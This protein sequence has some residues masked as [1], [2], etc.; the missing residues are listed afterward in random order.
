VAQ[1]RRGYLRPY[2]RAHDRRENPDA[3]DRGEAQNWAWPVHA[4]VAWLAAMLG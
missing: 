3:Y 4:F 1:N 2:N